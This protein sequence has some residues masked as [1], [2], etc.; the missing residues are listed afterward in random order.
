[1]P[2]SHLFA[3]E[4]EE[5]RGTVRRFI[6]N[7]ETDLARLW[8]I[9]AEFASR[10][11]AY[12]EEFGFRSIRYEVADPS[13][14]E[15]PSLTLSLIADQLRTGYDPAARAAE[16]ARRREAARAEA[17][18]LLAGRP[19]VDR[20]RFERALDR[21]ERWY[22][23]REDYA[24]MTFSEQLALIRR[25]ALEMGRRLAES[26]LI[27][28]PDDIFFLEGEEAGAA[29]AGRLARLGELLQRLAAVVDRVIA[30]VEARQVQMPAQLDAFVRCQRMQHAYQRAGRRS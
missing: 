23:A 4:H 10:F 3:P 14:L 9:D 26:S 30:G 27:D 19:E 24:P 16:V 12:Q 11:C 5:F 17:R 22:P 1:V 20:A 8:E 6:E 13:I 28:G 21:A 18:A 15:T 29:L 25:V 7:G 2:R